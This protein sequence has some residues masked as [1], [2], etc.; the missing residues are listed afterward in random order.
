VGVNELLRR[1]LRGKEGGGK[2]ALLCS[3]L[4][5]DI[6]QQRQVPLTLNADRPEPRVFSTACALHTCPQV[7][8]QIHACYAQTMSEWLGCEA[9]VRQRE[10]ESHAAALAKCSSGASLDSHL[11]RMLHRDSTISNEVKD[12]WPEGNADGRGQGLG[13]AAP[14]AF[15]GRKSFRIRYR[16]KLHPENLASAFPLGSALASVLRAWWRSGDS[17]EKTACIRFHC[18]I[19]QEKEWNQVSWI[20]SPET[21]F[22]TFCLCLSGSC[23]SQSSQ[24][25]SSGRQNLRLQSD[26]SSSTQVTF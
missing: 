19:C 17:P 16:F 23:L 11:H 10:R 25:C 24:S 22:V 26:S 12:S 8:E 18:C 2:L 20:P 15:E 13:T 21:L 14:S 1:E 5:M 6:I 3:I 9:I 7:D 4:G